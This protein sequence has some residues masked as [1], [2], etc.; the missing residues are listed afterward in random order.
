VT[1]L[2]YAA[3]RYYASFW[4]RF[5]SPD[6]SWA[7]VDL[8]TPQSWNRYTYALGDPI[9]GNDP[10]G[11]DDDDYG[12][13]DGCPDGGVCFSG[14]GGGGGGGGGADG[15]GDGTSVTSTFQSSCEDGYA[16]DGSGGCDPS[17]WGSNGGAGQQILARRSRASVAF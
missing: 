1:D 7:S 5:T 11:L 14:G 8:R 6:P 13:E 17:I 2:D 9:A 12:N 3:N 15:G 10:S 4:A 16:P